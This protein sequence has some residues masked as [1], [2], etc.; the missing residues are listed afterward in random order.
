MQTTTY[1]LVQCMAGA[2]GRGTTEAEATQNAKQNGATM[3]RF[4]VHEVTQDATKPKPMI[5]GI[6]NLVHYG[7]PFDDSVKTRNYLAGKT[8][9]R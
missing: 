6:G 1:Y 9:T 7:N 5:D 3:K 8:A 2:W 4:L